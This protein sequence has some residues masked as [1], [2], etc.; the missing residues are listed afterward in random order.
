MFQEFVEIDGKKILVS[1]GKVAKQAN[2]SVLIRQGDTIVLV[3]AVQTQEQ[4]QGIDF[5][6]L[7][8]EYRE[9]TAAAGNIPGG[10]FKRE[11][12]PSD[13]ETLTSRIVD[14]SLRPL[15]PKSLRNETQVLATVLSFDPTA[16]PNVLAITG[17]SIALSISD[18][19]WN[20]PLAG[21]RV[22][23]KDGKLSANPGSSESENADL[24]LMI[25]V[26][27]EG[28]AMVEGEAREAQE[29]EVIEALE[30]AQRMAG[31]ILQA[32]E[33]L[34]EKIGKPKCALPEVAEV[35]PA[36]LEDLRE[37]APSEMKKILEGSL[38]KFERRDALAALQQ[39]MVERFA[40]E[41]QEARGERANLVA[42]AMEKILYKT[43][44]GLLLEKNVRVDGRDPKSVRD[45]WGEVAW[46][47]RAHGSALFTRGETQAMVSCTLGTTREGQIVEKLDGEVREPFLLHYNFPPYSVGEVRML[48]GP[49]RREIGH[50][51]LARRALIHVLPDFD[52]FPYTIR[53]VSDISES[54][55]SS[56]M[57][58][59]CG[60]C[61]ALMDAGIPI[62][63]PVA[64]IAMGLVKEGDRTVI[65]SDILGD[66]DHLGDMDFKV[67]GTRKGITAL[68]LDNKI[69]QLPR[70]VLEAGLEQAK[71]GRLHILGEMAKILDKPRDEISP[72]APRTTTL[73]IRKE[74]I[75]DLIGPGGKIIQAIQA[76]FGVQIEVNDDGVVRVYSTTHSD[77]DKALQTIKNHT[78]DLEV[79]RIYRG[80]V[81]SIKDFGAFV[82]INAA[83]E[84]LVHISELDSQRVNRVDDVLAEG[85]EV[86]VK[87]LDVDR[88]G[89]IRLSRK[90]ALGAP[91][92]AIEN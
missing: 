65:L 60:G 50:G 18:I 11:M 63:A 9:R 15:F 44:R 61:L 28:I 80:T 74:R 70:E 24:N 20:G 1:T 67:A 68:Q 87:V 69:G 19:V 48:R 2:G 30:F 49:G 76:D 35:S 17:A 82:R 13:L 72:Y 64:G 29:S 62:Q 91:E 90:A 83:T 53:V 54:N 88:A 6:P 85:D 4:R 78:S 75:R 89:K 23:K 79:G 51:N 16:D 46:L 37:T 56:S 21:V 8:V 57:A 71:Q 31:P 33:R 12:R 92:S 32:T 73:T 55:G 34:R 25:T 84:G 22:I 39:K 27:A 36:W 3:T 66:E 26:S 86:V 58:T 81:V 5:V 59:V 10:F 45:I 40:G 42:E 38:A 14:R 41:D 47:P 7:T 52:A 77:L 43:L